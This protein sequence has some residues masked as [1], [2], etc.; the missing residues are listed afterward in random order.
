ME[1]ELPASVRFQPDIV[2]PWLV[3]ITP[4]QGSFSGKF[5]VRRLPGQ[6]LAVVDM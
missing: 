1:F 3:T 2:D 5:T 6:P 4:I